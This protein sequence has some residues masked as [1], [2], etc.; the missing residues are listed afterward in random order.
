VL[1]HVTLA[2]LP[3]K[4]L[5]ITTLQSWVDPRT[6]LDPLN[7]KFLIPGMHSLL[8]FAFFLSAIQAIPRKTIYILI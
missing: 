2:S 7:N 5:P 8:L 1:F 3:R 4:W 6:G